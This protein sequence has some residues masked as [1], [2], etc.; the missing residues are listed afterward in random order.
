MFENSSGISR[1]ERYAASCH[2][3]MTMPSMAMHPTTG[4]DRDAGEFARE[5][6]HERREIKGDAA[7]P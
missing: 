7:V 4:T 2:M 1:C 5:I 3:M 6:C